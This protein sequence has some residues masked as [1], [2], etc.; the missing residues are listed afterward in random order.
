MTSRQA[1][2]GIGSMLKDPTWK[3]GILGKINSKNKEKSK[4]LILIKYSTS[5]CHPIRP[6]IA[7]A[8]NVGLKLIFYIISIIQS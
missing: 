2:L 4:Y 1:H 8:G 5:V 6:W 7:Q 3:R